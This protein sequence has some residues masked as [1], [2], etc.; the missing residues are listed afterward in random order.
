MRIRAILLIGA[1]AVIVTAMAPSAAFDSGYRCQQ[2]VPVAASIPIPQLFSFNT[3][4]SCHFVVNCPI[5]AVQCVVTA[6]A[7]ASGTGVVGAEVSLRSPATDSVGASVGGCPGSCQTPFASVTLGPGQETT[8][9]CHFTATPEPTTGQVTP[10]IALGA[11][12]FC[13]AVRN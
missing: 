10:S 6:S 9:S 11:T 12:I 8:V 4:P 1:F 3:G 13:E 7:T 5:L 2:S